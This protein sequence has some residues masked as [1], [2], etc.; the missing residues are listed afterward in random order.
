MP[1]IEIKYK[2]QTVNYHTG[3]DSDG[4]YFVSMWGIDNDTKHYWSHNILLK[5][6]TFD[7]VSRYARNA[8]RGTIETRNTRGLQMELF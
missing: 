1:K 2:G 8:V 6:A 7:T 3:N 5:N 4:T